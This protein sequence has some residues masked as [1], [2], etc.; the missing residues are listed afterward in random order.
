M[1]TKNWKY[2]GVTKPRFAIKPTKH[3]Q[4]VWDYP[5][6]PALVA[7]DREILVAFKGQILAKS[8]T[9]IKVLETAGAPTFYLPPHDVCVDLLEEVT[10]NS[11]CE[12][13]GLASYYRIRGESSHQACC[14][15]Y[16]EPNNTFHAIRGFYSFYPAAVD[17]YIDEQS[18][19]PQ[20]GGFYGGWVT[21]EIVG[22]IKGEPGSE[23]W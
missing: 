1:I 22:P 14:W 19:N 8:N 11:F 23:W 10:G 9:A 3:Q 4:S 13:K 18:V 7:D 21:D 15:V 16:R 5:R 2:D 20:P 12:W 17:C 6:P